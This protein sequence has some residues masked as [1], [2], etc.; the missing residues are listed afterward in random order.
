MFKKL[1]QWLMSWVTP[2][3]KKTLLLAGDERSL[4]LT[5][6]T[7]EDISLLA[8]Q[9]SH[10]VK[11]YPWP[12]SYYLLIGTVIGENGSVNYL[13]KDPVSN[14]EFALSQEIVNILLYHG[15]VKR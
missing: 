3:D 2:M 4:D 11:H 10:L 8:K 7:R 1:Y 6:L 12:D 15:G 13:F 14:K 5:G 9:D